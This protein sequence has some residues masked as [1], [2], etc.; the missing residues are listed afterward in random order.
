MSEWLL[1]LIVAIVAA[2]GAYTAARYGRV[3]KLERRVDSLEARE[4]K[5][6]LYCRQL[7]DHIWRGR[8]A[9]P[10]TPPEDAFGDFGEE[11]PA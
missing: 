8:G 3:G 7:I 4:R 10:P 2:A 1:A 6:W 9:P 11:E 5:L